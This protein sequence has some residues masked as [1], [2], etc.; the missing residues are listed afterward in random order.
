MALPADLGGGGVLFF[1]STSTMYSMASRASTFVSP[2]LRAGRD[3]YEVFSLRPGREGGGVVRG[4]SE[5]NI[6]LPAARKVNN[7]LFSN[8]TFTVPHL[9]VPISSTYAVTE[10]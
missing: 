9:K 2:T 10:I 3:K 4:K 6:P 7:K 8:P 1:N 5:F